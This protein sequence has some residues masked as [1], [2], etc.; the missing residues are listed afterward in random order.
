MHPTVN[1]PVAVLGLGK[2]KKK[3]HPPSG[4][5]SRLAGKDAKQPRILHESKKDK[6]GQEGKRSRGGVG[7]AT[8]SSG[9]V[10]IGERTFYWHVPPWG[11]EAE[12]LRIG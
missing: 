10:Q 5:I 9:T 12:R 4:R 6:G 8:G 2:D 3:T 1:E 11:T 7:K